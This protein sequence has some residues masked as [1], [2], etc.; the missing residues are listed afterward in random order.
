MRQQIIEL[1][2]KWEFAHK[3]NEVFEAKAFCVYLLLLFC[4]FLYLRFFPCHIVLQIGL[5]H[6]MHSLTHSLGNRDYFF[7]FVFFLLLCL[8]EFHENGLCISIEQCSMPLHILLHTQTH[9]WFLRFA[10]ECVEFHFDSVH[11]CGCISF[12]AL[13]FNCYCCAQNRH[14]C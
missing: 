14:F 8:F 1:N 11:T 9:W 12:A 4:C 2:N 3:A 6:T 10:H 7:H 5:V 13:H